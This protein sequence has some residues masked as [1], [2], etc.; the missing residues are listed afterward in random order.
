VDNSLVPCH[1]ASSN[2][3]EWRHR[4][5]DA[6]KDQ[7]PEAGTMNQFVDRTRAM[8][9]VARLK[10]RLGKRQQQKKRAPRSAGATAARAGRA[11]PAMSLHSANLVRN[12]RSAIL[13]IKFPPF[14]HEF[15][16]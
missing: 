12:I 2:A 6:E 13:A 16:V 8:G 11:R 1:Q 3:P 14:A 10:D 7:R 15:H 4:E 5:R 9:D